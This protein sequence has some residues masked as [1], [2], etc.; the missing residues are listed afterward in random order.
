[1][2]N[3]IITA[4]LLL[5]T[6]TIKAQD[7][8]IPTR[9]ELEQSIDEYYNNL[10]SAQQKENEDEGKTGILHYIPSPTYNPFAGGFGVTL[11][12]TAPLQAIRLKKEKKVKNEAIKRFNDL[13]AKDLKNKVDLKLQAIEININEI[14]SKN[15]IDTLKQNVFKII[16]TQYKQNEVAPT[17]FLT[18][19][20]NFE[21]YK[22]Q[23]QIEK[24]EIQK[25]IIE[26]LIEAKKAATFSSDLSKK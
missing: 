10:T 5:S 12:L 4:L 13:Q 18:A 17:D 8:T 24:N 20:Q 22:I 7:F 1:M 15:I 21:A 25:Q 19:A 6:I 14:K 11:N 23:R 16:Q 9:K 26:L 3:K 2:K